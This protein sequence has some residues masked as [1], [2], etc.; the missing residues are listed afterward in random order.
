MLW[1]VAVTIHFTDYRVV[2]H[3]IDR[4]LFSINLPT[5][6]LIMCLLAIHKYSFIK[7]LLKYFAYL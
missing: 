3:C 5:E 7:L 2:Y 1:H 4:P 6:H